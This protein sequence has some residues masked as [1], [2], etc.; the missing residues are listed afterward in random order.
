MTNNMKEPTEL[1][2]LIE[3]N[4]SNFKIKK[5]VLAKK[6]E[7]S[8]ASYE[9]IMPPSNL[10]TV[11]HARANKHYPTLVSMLEDSAEKL[12]NGYTLIPKD[13]RRTGRGYKVVYLKEETQ[14]IKEKAELKKQVKMD[15]LADLEAAKQVWVKELTETLAEKA[16]AEALVTAQNKTKQIQAELALLLS[17]K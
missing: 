10:D 1:N 4:K 6:I 11:L 13:T 12:S 14:Q 8:L 16:K 5:D 2:I 7:Y 15:Y 9:M 17:T 3:E